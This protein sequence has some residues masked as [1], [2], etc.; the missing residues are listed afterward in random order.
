LQVKNT[1]PSYTLRGYQLRYADYSGH[2]Q[3]IALP[4]MQPGERYPL[5]LHNV[6]PQYAFEVMRP[7]GFSVIKY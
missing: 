6:N 4:D 1:I 2:Q 7:N 5:V 3:T